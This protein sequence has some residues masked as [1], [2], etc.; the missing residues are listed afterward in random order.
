ML[1]HV[2]FFFLIGVCFLCMILESILVK[3]YAKNLKSCSP[4]TQTASDMMINSLFHFK[5]EPKS[6]IQLKGNAIVH[7]HLNFKMKNLKTQKASVKYLSMATIYQVKKEAKK[8]N[9]R[10][11]IWMIHLVNS[12]LLKK[13]KKKR[14][15]KNFKN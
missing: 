3:L 14:F 4:S 2:R 7:H 15:K 11:K 10:E 12:L 9:P 8:Q 5:C 13:L 6:D 1:N